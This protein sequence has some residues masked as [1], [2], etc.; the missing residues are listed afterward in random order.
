MS[1]V[2]TTLRALVAV[3][4]LVGIYVLVLGLAMLDAVLVFETLLTETTDAAD[5]S[6]PLGALI[7]VP[8]V[9]A[10]CWGL[11]TASRPTFTDEGSV[12]LTPEQ[13]PLLWSTT[14]QLADAVGTSPPTE[15]RLVAEVNAA[16]TEEA[17]LLGLVGGRRRLYLGLPLVLGLTHDELRAVIA[18]ELG[19]YA[20]RHTRLLAIT[21]RSRE[22][23]R[24]VLRRLE[25]AA[26]VASHTA[27]FVWVLRRFF[28]GYTKCFDL[29]TLAMGRRQE[30]EA[31]AVAARVAVPP[32]AGPSATVD[33]R[34]V[35]VD[36]LRALGALTASWDRLIADYVAPGREHGIVPERP[37]DLFA[38][39]L[40]DVAHRAIVD[41]VKMSPPEPKRTPW[42]TH[43]S[44]ARR[45]A[46]LGGAS[47]R[48]GGP[49]RPAVALLGDWDLSARRLWGKSEIG[50]PSPAV[51]PLPNDEWRYRITALLAGDA[52]DRLRAVAAQQSDT[53]NP[54]VGEVLDLLRSGHGARLATALT[55]EVAAD[56]GT[57]AAAEVPRDRHEL[58][59]HLAALVGEALVAAGLARWV[60]SWTQPGLVEAIRAIPPYSNLVRG[61]PHDP[62]EATRLRELLNSIGVD[63]E[64]SPP[65][66]RYRGAAAHDADGG[67][68]A[69]DEVGIDF[70]PRWR[71]VLFTWP[72]REERRAGNVFNALMLGALVVGSVAVAVYVAV[73]DPDHGH[74]EPVPTYQPLRPGGGGPPGLGTTGSRPGDP[75][76]VFPSRVQLTPIHPPLRTLGPGG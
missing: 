59:V 19:H 36:A 71:R 41:Q 3:G 58:T 9:G 57:P 20:G 11:A 76:R 16:V 61:A 74:E 8:V 51:R 70:T 30:F 1:G 25:L 38:A 69:A 27:A 60:P 39:M 47:G 55:A 52:A 56:R 10:L 29:L 23:L 31:D 17:W 6:N 28:I 4:L 44:L 73:Y 72:T 49:G 37:F 42:D 13:A 32:A 5:T 7:T 43:P 65:P 62:D 12:P 46:A 53:P 63:L 2:V 54:G 15:I 40:D 24:E 26:R 50:L 35:V 34:G 18:H 68:D 14:R 33:G 45:I 67:A 64:A 22:S 66:G 21:H 48:H 75:G